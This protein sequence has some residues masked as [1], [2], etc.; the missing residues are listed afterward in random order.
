MTLAPDQFGNAGSCFEGYEL[1]IEAEMLTR[2][3]RA[4]LR[5]VAILAAVAGCRIVGRSCREFISMARRGYG[6]I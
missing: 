6:A 2:R 5:E 4:D 3:W 1:R